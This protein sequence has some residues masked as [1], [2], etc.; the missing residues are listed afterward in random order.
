MENFGFRSCRKLQRMRY[1]HAS[2]CHESHNST[3]GGT[4]FICVWVIFS[5]AESSWIYKYVPIKNDSCR[6]HNDSI[7]LFWLSHF[8]HVWVICILA[9]SYISL[10]ESF[11][12]WR[13]HIVLWLSHF[14]FRRSHFW[15]ALKHTLK[16][17]SHRDT[18]DSD[19]IWN[20]SAKTKCW[21]WV[22]FLVAESFF[23]WRSQ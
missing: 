4:I 13:S 5:L 23:F 2:I 10:S 3:S 19:A 22:I 9:E 7:D 18:N 14:Y 12:F 21:S 15:N 8:F 16:N 1:F 6:F 20:D 11:Y 17:D